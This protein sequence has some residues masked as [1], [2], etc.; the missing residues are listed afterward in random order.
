MKGAVEALTRY[1]AKE[2]GCPWHHRQ[3][4]ARRAIAT[5]FSG[6]VVRDNPDVNAMV[7][8][9]TALGRAGLPDDIWAGRFYPAGRR[10]QLDHRAT[11]RGL[12]RDVSVTRS[13]FSASIN[14]F[15][16]TYRQSPMSFDP[17]LAGGMGELAAV[18]DSGKFAGAADSLETTPSGVSRADSA[19]GKRLA[20]AR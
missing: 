20:S 8:N 4:L 3:H 1:Q 6:G 10:Q 9:N 7:A 19:A 16:V 2:P 17:G 15:P 5:D 14:A 13:G 12:G 11:G 18:V